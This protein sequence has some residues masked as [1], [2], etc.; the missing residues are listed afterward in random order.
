MKSAWRVG[1]FLRRAL[2]LI[3][4]LAAVVALLIAY[5]FMTSSKIGSDGIATE[6]ARD[7]APFLIV[8]AAGLLPTAATAW[9]GTRKW[10]AWQAAV[11]VW[12]AALIAVP[13]I[14][15]LIHS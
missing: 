8:I 11:P 13:L 12:V 10:W 3:E 15:D 14:W 7:V 4:G 6:I 5:D 1:T 2:A 9:L